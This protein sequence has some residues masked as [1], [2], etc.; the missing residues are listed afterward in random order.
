MQQPVSV[1]VTEQ[2]LLKN[3]ASKGDCVIVGRCADVVSREQKPL[4]L[5]VYADTQSKLVRYQQRAEAGEQLPE[6]ELLRR[7]KQI[8][9]GRAVYRGLFTESDW[10]KRKHIIYASTHQEKKSRT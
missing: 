3:L 9:K 2:E 5:F 6:R 10:A 7:M 8:D 4:N 1:A